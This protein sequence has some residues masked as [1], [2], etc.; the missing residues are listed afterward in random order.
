MKIHEL[1]GIGV[2]QL[3]AS[4]AGGAASPGEKHGSPQ[5]SAGVDVI[6]LSPQARLMQKAAQVVAETP[7]VRSEKVR[8]LKDSVAQGTY[9]VDTPKVAEKLITEMLLEKT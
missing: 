5:T 7:E 6:H 2:E 1:P 8:A 4:R 3:Q 9:A